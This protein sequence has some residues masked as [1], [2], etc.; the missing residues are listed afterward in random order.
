[1]EFPLSIQD[2]QVKV[3]L[4]YLTYHG[5]YSDH[6][7]IPVAR[8]R[9]PRVG[10]ADHRGQLCDAGVHQHDACV[11]VEVWVTRQSVRQ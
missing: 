7:D 1:M 2:F 8:L 3:H 6:R 11:E 4:I 9:D 10:Q 5:L